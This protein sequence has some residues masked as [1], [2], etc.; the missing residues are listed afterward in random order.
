LLDFDTAGFVVVARATGF[1]AAVRVAGLAPV[2][3]GLVVSGAAK[4]AAGLAG[5]DAG[6]IVSLLSVLML[7]LSLS[8]KLVMTG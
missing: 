7:A 8:S 2:E 1:F 3:A 6:A 5:V 4:R